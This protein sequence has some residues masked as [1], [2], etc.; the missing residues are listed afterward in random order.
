MAFLLSN[1]LVCYGFIVW[2][3]VFPACP[4]EM[5]PTVWSKTGRL[6]IL[7]GSVQVM[8]VMLTSSW[9]AFKYGR[10]VFTDCLEVKSWY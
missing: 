3:Y 9:F 2:L 10:L 6:P 1:C 5:L 4:A 7:R 8:L